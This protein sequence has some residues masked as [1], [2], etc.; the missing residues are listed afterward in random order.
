WR[1]NT[2]S[3]SIPATT[4]IMKAI[5]LSLW[6]A[7]VLGGGLAIWNY[8]ANRVPHAPDTLEQRTAR[9]F[10][11]IRNQPDRLQA[12]LKSMPKGADLHTHLSG[13]VYAETFL[14]WA[15]KARMCVDPTTFVV[16]KR[17]RGKT[18]VRFNK[19]LSK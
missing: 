4:E 6:L 1:G 8:P 16:S 17:C 9:H 7:I 13:A 19:D 12:F 11:S 3:V 2:D 14:S 5:L 18:P 10:Q 15:A